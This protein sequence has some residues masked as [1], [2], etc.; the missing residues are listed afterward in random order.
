[1]DDGMEIKN[2]TENHFMN[3]LNH[4]LE[5][6][7]DKSRVQKWMESDSNSPINMSSDSDSDDCFEHGSI[8][9]SKNGE[10][11]VFKKLTFREV[12]SSIEKYYET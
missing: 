8:E 12:E 4:E 5:N 9:S 1:M 7:R 10:K 3:T 11:T 2:Y 6:L